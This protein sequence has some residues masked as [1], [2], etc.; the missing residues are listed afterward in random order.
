VLS[1]KAFRSVID[2]VLREGKNSPFVPDIEEQVAKNG[3]QA[4]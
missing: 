4:Q 2:K 3:Y 1:G